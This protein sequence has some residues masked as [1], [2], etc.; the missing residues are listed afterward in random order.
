[1]C[2]IGQWQPQGI[3]SARANAALADKTG[4]RFYSSTNFLCQGGCRAALQYL[5]QRLRTQVTKHSFPV[6][7]HAAQDQ[8]ARIQKVQPIREARAGKTGQVWTHWL[9]KANGIARDGSGPVMIGKKLYLRAI[10]NAIICKNLLPK[11]QVGMLRKR[12]IVLE[13]C[14]PA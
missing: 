10:G 7:V 4:R 6:V 5:V 2:S 3:L 11:C 9:F 14:Y 13:R 8:L 12:E 1:M